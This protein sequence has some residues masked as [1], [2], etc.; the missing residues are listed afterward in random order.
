M[1]ASAIIAPEAARLLAEL[2]SYPTPDAVDRARVAASALAPE[3]A[4]P[5]LRCADALRAIGPGE[6]EELYTATFDLRPAASPYLGLLLCGEG[7]R[8]NALLAWLAETYAA[9]GH[10]PGSELPDHVAEVLRFLADAGDSDAAR[11]LAD[12]ALRPCARRLAAAVPAEN[13]YRAALDA[14]CR[15]LGAGGPEEVA[16]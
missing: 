3:V 16:P 2:L 9:A 7:A 15:A 11:E 12:L 5:A 4:T 13:P 8:R 14:L 10:A 6:A 1:S